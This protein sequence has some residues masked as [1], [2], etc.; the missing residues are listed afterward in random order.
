M[1]LQLLALSISAISL[2]S[3]IAA[4]ILAIAN[5]LNFNHPSTELPTATK[6]TL[7][8]QRSGEGIT[9]D[10]NTNT[11]QTP[12]L[13]KIRLYTHSAQTDFN[14]GS[15]RI[16]NPTRGAFPKPIP[17][18]LRRGSKSQARFGKG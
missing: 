5:A 13:Q 15:R 2:T 17:D 4:P 1:K 14:F 18:K 6:P 7:L 9:R 10:V 12:L 16:I 8:S 3:I 11:N